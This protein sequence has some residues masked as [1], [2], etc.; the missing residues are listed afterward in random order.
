MAES[1]TC[2]SCGAT[3]YNPNDIRHSY[4]GACHEWWDRLQPGV[5]AN[6]R[7]EMHLHVPEMLEANGYADTPEN[8]D[9]LTRVATAMCERLGMAMFVDDHA[10]PAIVEFQRWIIDNGYIGGAEMTDGTIVAV[11]PTVVGQGLLIVGDRH[12]VAERYSYQTPEA[13]VF[14][15]LD[16]RANEWEGEPEGWHRH[17]PTNRR[18]TNGDPAQ[19][20][21]RP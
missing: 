11:M 21:V 17:Q 13:A 1:F 6:D 8:R 10:N 15:M 14:A 7:G 9:M 5:Y 12:S 3:S 2:P 16:W 19:E 4:C 20:T 18:R